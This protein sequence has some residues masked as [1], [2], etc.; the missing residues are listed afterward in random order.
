MTPM[1]IMG[2]AL[3][4]LFILTTYALCKV[5]SDAD[6]EAERMRDEHRSRYDG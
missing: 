4:V 5:A 6:D 1:K 2:I 3:I